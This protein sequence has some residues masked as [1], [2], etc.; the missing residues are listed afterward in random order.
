M[1]RRT[2]AGALLAAVLLALG[3]LVA[4]GAHADLQHPRQAFLRDSVGGLF[5]HWGMRTSPANTTCGGFG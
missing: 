1:N 5:L 3:M 4:P 2:R